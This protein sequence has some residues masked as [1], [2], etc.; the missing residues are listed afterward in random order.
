MQHHS[1]K[2]PRSDPKKARSRDFKFW[3]SPPIRLRIFICRPLLSK[4]LYEYIWD[5]RA[6][7]N[8]RVKDFREILVPLLLLL[9][10]TINWV[11]VSSM[12]F[13]SQRSR[14]FGAESN[15]FTL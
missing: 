13:L 5:S 4:V 14:G 1:P 10:S 15:V 7:G 8:S 11:I 12:I 3:R 2:L 6:V 9:L